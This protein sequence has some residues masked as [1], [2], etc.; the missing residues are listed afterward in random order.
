MLLRPILA[1]SCFALFLFAAVALP[2]DD[3][4][5]T[6]A[7][8]PTLL[9]ALRSGDARLALRWRYESVD[10]AR[11]AENAHA[12]TG[13]TALSYITG[14][15]RGW[16][17]LVEAE[18]VTAI[19]DDDDYAN[20]G[21]GSL[22]NGVTDRPVI[23]DPAGT[24]IH[25]AA[26]RYRSDRLD[27]TL[28]RQAINLGD[29]RFV[30]AVAWR[31]NHQSFDAVRF[32]WKGSER[33][34]VDATVA[35]RAHRIFGDAVDLDGQWL[36]APIQ[37]ADRQTLTPYYYGI[38]FDEAPT[39]S[40]TTLGVELKGRFELNDGGVLRYE[41]EWA[42]QDDVGD[43][44][45]RID[46]QYALASLGADFGRVGLDVTWE[47]LGGRGNG[48]ASFQTPL[49]TLH[50]WNGWADKFLRTPAAGLDTLYVRLRGTVGTAW[51]WSVVY[52]D[53]TSEEDGLD[54]GTEVDGEVVYKAPWNQ[55]FGLK[56]A[57]Y[58][59]DLWSTDTPKWMLWSSIVF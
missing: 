51:R 12:L 14:E 43:N 40:T 1:A 4:P 23:A 48:G 36:L 3:A 13:R 38:D 20:A 59:A 32:V 34:S 49:A 10:D 50:K 24:E 17:L 55:Q 39:R 18:D 22:D 2:A 31:Q 56:I 8:E 52:H 6:D 16:S 9:D 45:L 26:L 57:D 35:R 58:D 46:T 7:T 54:Y 28:G 47:S 30:G 11:F 19:P 29:Q 25:Q 21:A 44:P 37:I 27:V 41:L 5:T 15:Y 33:W 53:F 42:Q